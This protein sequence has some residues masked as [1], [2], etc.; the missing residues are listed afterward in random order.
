M[1]PE[2]NRA[3]ARSPS[4]RQRHLHRRRVHRGQRQDRASPRCAQPRHRRPDGIRPPS[5]PVLSLAFSGKLY[6]GG[7][8][9]GGWLT[10]YTTAG[11]EGVAG[12]HRRRLR[13]DRG[14]GAPDHRRRPLR[15]RLLE[16]QRC[17]NKVLRHQML[18]V[19]PGGAVTAF[20]P[21]VNSVLGSV[22][23]ARLQ[24]Q[25]V[26]RRRLYGDQ[27]VDAQPSRPVH[28]Q[29]TARPPGRRVN[30]TDYETA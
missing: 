2:V 17:G 28:V 22:R 24:G 26:G 3:V 7:S 21:T 20:A 16:G 6:V 4:A 23:S 5:F 14:D 11:K 25:P 13:C 10:A 18:A 12:A 15:Q 8:G 9:A 19:G 30:P 27:R 29:L 1:E